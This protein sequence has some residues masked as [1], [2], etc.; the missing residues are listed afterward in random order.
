MKN[1]KNFTNF[2]IEICVTLHVMLVFNFKN[3]QILISSCN[4]DKRFYDEKDLNHIQLPILRFSYT[5]SPLN[6]KET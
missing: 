3:L 6:Q 1:F 4:R 5:R 2:V